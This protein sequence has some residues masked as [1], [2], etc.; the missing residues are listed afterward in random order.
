MLGN[1]T[2]PLCEVHFAD[3][4]Q[5]RAG[6]SMNDYGAKASRDLIV[7]RGAGFR[8]EKNKKKRGVSP[9]PVLACT[10]LTVAE[11][12]RRRDHHGDSQYQV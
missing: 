12:R 7:T 2:S 5:T 9:S 4:V 11:L 3:Y 1:V 10:L 8:K 6:A